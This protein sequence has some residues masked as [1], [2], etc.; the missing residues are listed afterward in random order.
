MA[1]NLT[2]GE[3]KRR[4]SDPNRISESAFEIL[5]ALCSYASTPDTEHRAQELILRALEH[6]KAFSNAISVLD[7]LVR[8]VG[9]FP[10]LEQ[11]DLGLAD[12]IAYEFHRPENMEGD[13]VVFHR[14]Q[15][16]VYNHLING[17]NVALSAPTSF[18]KSLLIDA[19]V[20]SRKYSNI[21]VV[22]PTIA[23]IDETRR[24]LSR[25]SPE[26]KIIT[27][28]SQQRR[29]KNLFVMTQ[30]RI[31]DVEKLEP[32]DF[33]VIDEF[34]KLQPRPEDADRSFLLNEAFY[35]LYKTGAQ[36]YL[37]GPN[38]KGLDMEVVNRLELHF[39]KTDYK[40]VASEI[41]HVKADEGDLE[42]L[43]TL[44]E[45]LPDPTLIYCSSPG[46][47]R[48]VAEALMSIQEPQAELGGAVNWVGEQYDPDWLYVKAM[49]RGIGVHHGKIPRALS[50]LVVRSFNE[51]RVKFLACTS[52]LIEGVNTMAKNVIVFDNK[53]ARRKF[54]Y[55]TYNNILGRSGRMFQHFVGHVYIFHEPPA[56][57]LPFVDFPVFSQQEGAPN[58]L[59]MQVDSEDLTEAA[60]ERVTK[61]TSDGELD[62]ETLRLGKGIDPEAQNAL[63]L[64]LRVRA[65]TYFPLLNWTRYPTW[66][67]LETACTLIWEF[68]VPD[69]R[70]R[71]GVASGRQLAFRIDRFRR[72]GSAG[73]FLK[74][75]LSTRGEKPADDIV[76]DAIDFLRSWANFA[77]PRFLM[78]VDG[79]QRAVF[80]KLGRRPGDYGFFSAQIQ[81]WFLDPAIMALDEYGIPTQLGQ[82]LDRYLRPEGDLDAALDRLRALNIERLPFSDFERSLIRDAVEYL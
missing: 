1:T 79:I 8:Q 44:C 12:S 68:L 2:L 37:L 25:F 42:A 35:R 82:R 34:Y 33:F 13:G 46:R 21:A 39:I 81:N 40:T 70:M 26:F 66:E 4:L 63:A 67:Q 48:K 36:F 17:D 16:Q 71:S 72:S 18:G 24:R 54:D 7:G 38:V 20:A 5:S 53:I 80:S 22:V 29:D 64:A 32:I 10:Y 9:L 61:A 69:G 27:H 59:L 15:A 55:F 50:Q 19:I 45:G 57:E 60:R 73:S 31:L 74:G 23:L 56:E 47:V 51:G 3:I 30:E 14:V 49:Q 65:A 58:S 11:D 75:E 52:T 62:L 78:V 43:V 41:H 28:G 77:F 6:R 76:E